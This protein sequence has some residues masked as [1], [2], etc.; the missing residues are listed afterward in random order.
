MENS[1][2]SDSDEPVTHE[3]VTIMPWLSVTDAAE[4][5]GFYRVAFG[6]TTGE[7]A[8]FD[9]AV[10]VAELFVGHATFWVQQDDDL[11]A[12][13]DPGRT[14]RMIVTVPD[15]AESFA[16]AIRAGATE[17]AAVHDENGWQTCRIADPFG[18]QW[19]FARRTQ[20]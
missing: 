17:L 2:T 19:E 11:P 15:P 8:E 13:A 9:G 1:E 18:H 16:A 14:V 5:V 6:A 12:D 3:P 20:G 7:V 4:A 10:Q